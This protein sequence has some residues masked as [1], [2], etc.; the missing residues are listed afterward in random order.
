MQADDEAVRD[1]EKV[2]EEVVL[3][4]LFA[5]LWEDIDLNDFVP[6]VSKCKEVQLTSQATTE[7]NTAI[8]L[9]SAVAFT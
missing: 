4:D 1:L 7:I 5:K 8:P 9:E 3:K 6:S 2:K